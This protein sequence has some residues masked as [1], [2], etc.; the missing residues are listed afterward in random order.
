MYTVAK[1]EASLTSGSR[2][3]LCTV[4]KIGQFQKVS[5][6]LLLINK[7]LLAW[8]PSWKQIM[9]LKSHS[10]IFNLVFNF[11]TICLQIWLKQQCTTWYV[12]VTELI[13]LRSPSGFGL[14]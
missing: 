14:F 10:T 3:I 12:L 1:S 13:K 8:Q 4:A 9:N 5:S 11:R 2:D 6:P 7:I